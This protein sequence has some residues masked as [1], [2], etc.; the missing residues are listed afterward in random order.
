MEINALSITFLVNVVRSL[1]QA[2][3]QSVVDVYLCNESMMMF[4]VVVLAALRGLIA[5]L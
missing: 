3:V 5:S 4:M 2:F 1:H